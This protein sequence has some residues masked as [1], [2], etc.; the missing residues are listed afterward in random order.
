MVPVFLF[1]FFT[2]PL[3]VLTDVA[4]NLEPDLIERVHRPLHNGRD[5]HT[6][7]PEVRTWRCSRRSIGHRHR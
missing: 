2:N 4:P 1:D 3:I 6:I 7:E 5:Q